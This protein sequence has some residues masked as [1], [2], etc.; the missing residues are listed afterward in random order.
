MSGSIVDLFYDEK[1]ALWRWVWGNETFYDENR[2]LIEFNTSLE[3]LEWIKK[4]HP[5]L[6][7]RV[8]QGQ[9]MTIGIKG[10]DK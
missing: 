2:Q 7:A 9:Q 6:T 1:H 3:A 8:S 5:E 4:E 10:D